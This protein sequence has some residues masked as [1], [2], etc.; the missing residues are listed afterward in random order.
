MPAST[1]VE[2]PMLLDFP[3]P[4]LLADP[5]ETIVV[6]KLEAHKTRIAKQ[7]NESAFIRRSRFTYARKISNS[8]SWKCAASLYRY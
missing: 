5:K 6:E 4:V 8:S 3:V 2:Y 7:P 1:E